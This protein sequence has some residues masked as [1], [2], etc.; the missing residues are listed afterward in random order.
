MNFRPESIGSGTMAALPWDGD[1][2]LSFDGWCQLNGFS[3]STGQRLIKAGKG[4]Q[5]MRAASQR[6]C[7]SNGTPMRRADSFTRLKQP[8]ERNEARCVRSAPP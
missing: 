5:L 4:P 3:R 6:R 1:R 2:V 7:S 8:P